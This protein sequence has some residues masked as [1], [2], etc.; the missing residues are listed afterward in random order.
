M[1]DH[2]DPE[3][4]APRDDATAERSVVVHAQRD[5]DG[6]D[7]SQLERLVELLPT[8]VR[9]ADAPH[10]TVI[11]EPR[12]RAERGRPRR[13]RIGRVDEIEVDRQPVERGEARLAVAVN[14][15]RAT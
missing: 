9:Y 11:R 15:L 12:Q 10:E 5:L 6:G 8:D 7:R 1:G 14:R 13:P 2:G 3:V 4:R